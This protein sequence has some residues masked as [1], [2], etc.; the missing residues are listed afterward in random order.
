[1]KCNLNFIAFIKS[2]R[3]KDGQR[4]AFLVQRRNSV[5]QKVIPDIS[6]R[7]LLYIS[8]VQPK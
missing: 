5:L 2:F 8:E 1:M 7:N 3:E 4:L 6:D